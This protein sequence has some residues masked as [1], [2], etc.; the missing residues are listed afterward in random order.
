M[1]GKQVLFL[2]LNSQSDLLFSLIIQTAESVNH[3][4]G[5]TT[6]RE[7]TINWLL[8]NSLKMT[9]WNQEVNVCVEEMGISHCL[10]DVTLNSLKIGIFRLGN[11]KLLVKINITARWSY[12]KT[13]RQHTQLDKMPINTNF[14]SPNK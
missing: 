1:D 14:I 7:I 9:D 11:V 3:S 2:T 4:T 5:S 12:N 13:F 8:F 6:R 10:Q